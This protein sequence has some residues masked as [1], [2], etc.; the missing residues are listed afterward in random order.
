V[1]ESK[2]ERI[3]VAYFST[4]DDLLGAV[5]SARKA[6]WAVADVYTPY[7]VH[8]LDEAM[9]LKPSRLTW[10]CFLAGLTGLCLALGFEYY[11]SAVSWPLNVGGKPY[12]SFP[13]FI[14][15]A[16]ELTVLTAGLVTVAALFLRTRLYPGRK[17]LTLPGVTNDRFA[18]ALATRGTFEEGEADALLK[19]HGATETGYAEAVS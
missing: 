4:E 11:T 17:G 6:G 14:P 12:D 13:A 10:V 5:T 18:L 15:V 2:C 16:F 19:G 9:G 1:N 8:G 7:A 3:F